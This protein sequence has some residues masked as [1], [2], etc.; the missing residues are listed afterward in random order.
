V[1]KRKLGNKSFY[2]DKELR[3]IADELI[4]AVTIP[5]NVEAEMDHR[6]LNLIEV[7]AI[8]RGSDNIFLS[9]CGC[10]SI[11]KNCDSPLDTCI[12]INVAEDYAEKNPANNPHRI[13]VEEALEVL[14]KSHE[15][16]LVHMAYVFKGEDKPQL[17]CSCCPCCC[18]T[19]GG[20]LR[21]G[22]TTQ[23]LTSKF[24]SV[25][26]DTRCINCGKCV[27]RCVFGARAMVKGKKKL[28]KTLCFGCG[29]C[30]STCSKEAIK[31]VRRL[32]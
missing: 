29:L 1:A 3:E 22:I 18:H 4:S 19:L 13:N 25:D 14:R 30:V 26:D 6:V 24:I 28:D 10:R 11:H 17:I 21:H 20:I 5:V 23:V 27:E 15:V 31:L 12:A 8:L 9:D 2:S 7:E 16:G 32:I